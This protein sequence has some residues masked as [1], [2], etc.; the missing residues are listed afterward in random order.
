MGKVMS[1][2]IWNCSCN[3]IGAQVHARERVRLR[4]DALSLC[5]IKYHMYLH[6]F[7]TWWFFWLLKCVQR[8]VTPSAPHRNMFHNFFLIICWSSLGFCEDNI[9]YAQDTR[10]NC[11][12]G[13]FFF[14]ACSRDLQYI[15]RVFGNNINYN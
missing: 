11:G 9:D 12:T 8:N 5:Q 6:T 10:W 2:V 4:C 13:L 15:A 7:R 14:N 1:C 3:Y